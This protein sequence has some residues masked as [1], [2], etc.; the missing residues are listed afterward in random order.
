MAASRPLR[1]PSKART[2][3]WKPSRAPRDAEE[4]SRRLIDALDAATREM[5]PVAKAAVKKFGVPFKGFDFS[6]S[7]FPEEW[8]SLGKAFEKLGV[9]SIG[10]IG[11]LTAAAILTNAL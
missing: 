11:S 1:W 8:C 6:L 5:V 2:P 10:Y 3:P 9:P 4:G 7:P